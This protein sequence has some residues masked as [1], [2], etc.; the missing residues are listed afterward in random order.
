M[1]LARPTVDHRAQGLEL[2]GALLPDSVNRAVT[3]SQNAGV[4]VLLV[5][6]LHDRAQEFYEHYGFQAA[7][8]SDDADAALELR[9]GLMAPAANAELG[10][11]GEQPGL[12]CRA[13][14]PQDTAP[15]NI[16]QREINQVRYW[17]GGHGMRLERQELPAKRTQTAF[18][19]LKD[20][21]RA[22]LT[23]DV[24]APQARIECQDVRVASD[25]VM[26][27]HPH[28]L[29]VEHQ[30]LR[31]AARSRRAARH[32]G[33]ARQAIDK[34]AVIMFADTIG[35]AIARHDAIRTRIDC[36]DLVPGLDVR[37][38]ESAHGII[39]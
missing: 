25:A 22:A 8:T 28:T 20:R 32:E 30:K 14:D 7:T 16:L 36:D 10:S 12:T 18:S 23:A 26:I 15:M 11:W 13:H 5:H 21:N 9:Q 35:Q 6:A 1:I 38:N 3:V 24:Q 29:H 4:R 19:Q 2:G 27:Q 31:V 33:S 34:Q 39:L 37:I 17:I